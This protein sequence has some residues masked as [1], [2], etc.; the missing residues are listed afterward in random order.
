MQYTRE[1][2]LPKIRFALA[3]SGNPSF[4]SSTPT[5]QDLSCEFVLI[6][7][8]S[9][10]VLRDSRSSTREGESANPEATCMIFIFS[11]ESAPRGKGRGRGRRLA[12]DEDRKGWR[13]VVQG[14]G[15][16]GRG[17]LLLVL[18]VVVGRA[19]KAVVQTSGTMEATLDS[20]PIAEGVGRRFCCCYC[21]CRWCWYWSWCWQ[22]C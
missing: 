7:A 13:R 17:W 5:S 20:N 16:R 12:K 8:H 15:E 11:T 4:R 21:C 19:S 10:D 6:P 18:V 22:C 9:N 1:I 3:K 2:S 14:E